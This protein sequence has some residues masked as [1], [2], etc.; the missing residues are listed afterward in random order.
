MN[1]SVYSGDSY[2]RQNQNCN[3]LFHNHYQF[4]VA[5]P[6]DIITTE[7]LFCKPLSQE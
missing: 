7:V 6:Q 4:D 5:D 1:S 2:G 3:S